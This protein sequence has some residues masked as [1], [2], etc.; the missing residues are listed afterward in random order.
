MI[1]RRRAPAVAGMFYSS[2]KEGLRDEIESAFLH[3]LG[4]GKLPEKLKGD[5]RPPAL[6]VPHA[7]YVYSGP[8]AAHAYAQLDGRRVV[9]VIILGPNHYGVGTPVSIYP[10]GEWLT[11]LG[12]VEV[13]RD[14]AMELAKKSDVFSLDEISHEREHSIEVQLPFLQYVLEEFKLVAICILDQSYQTSIKVGKTIAEV[15]KAYEDAA[16][17]A[18]TDFTHYEPHEEVVRKDEM[19]LEK[20]EN[21]DV[22]GLYEVITRHGISMCGYGGVAA[23]LQ[24]CKE[25]GAER[26]E[27][28]KH[29]TSGDITGDYGSVVGYGAVKLELTTRREKS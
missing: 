4:P 8:V 2:S 29:A 1:K 23:V 12:G 21:L 7:G 13:D 3:K 19:A 5:R 11:P 20:I 28:L 18:S 25:L 27:V 24:A 17:I 16:L 26:A 10:E 6:I 15:L 22:E 14:L 9:T